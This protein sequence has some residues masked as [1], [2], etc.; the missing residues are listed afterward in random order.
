LDLPGTRLQPQHTSTTGNTST[1]EIRPDIL[2]SAN[3]EAKNI[4]SSALTGKVYDILALDWRQIAMKSH[5]F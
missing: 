1:I 3:S 5:N 2:V 4:S